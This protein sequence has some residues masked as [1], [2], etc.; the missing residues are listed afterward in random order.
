MPAGRQDET[1]IARATRDML[2]T[3]YTPACVVVNPEGQ[4]LFIHGRTGKYLEHPQGKPSLNLLD[5]AREGLRYALASALRKA[6]SS[7][8]EVRHK[9]LRVKTNG[10]HQDLDLV[11]KSLSE[12]APLNHTFMV[13]FEDMEDQDEPRPEA[14]GK[15]EQVPELERELQKVRQEYQGT[16][17]ELESSNEE[18]RSANEET[19]S[20]NEELQSTN[21]ELESS[22]EE[23]QSLNEELST[24]NS[25][26]QNKTEE[27][28]RSYES[29]TGVLDSTQIAILFLGADLSISRFTREATR[30]FNLIETD[31]GRPIGHISHRLVY[32]DFIKKVRGV[33]DT[34]QPFEDEVRTKDGNWYRMRIMTHRRSEHRI[35][36]AVVT[37]INIDPQKRFAESIVDTV[38]E[39]LL[40]LDKEF[41]VVTANRR[42]YETFGL[43]PE[44]VEANPLFELGEGQWDIPALR[45]LLTRVVSEGKDFEDCRVDHRF[46]TLG[47][48]QMLVN[49]RLL[50]GRESEAPKILM[51]IED[52]TDKTNGKKYA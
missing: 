24:V 35:E 8:E 33:L 21:E 6:R 11:V 30:I 42:F 40:V 5:T 16:L 43:A 38:R 19:R 22:R 12:P 51:A 7:G 13:L 52:I 27:L 10:G 29:I 9:R 39:S 41:R 44:Q 1:L 20:S 50:Q 49:V 26:L 3:S 4:I 48:K 46:D 45:E 18:L 47:T 32:D 15:A 2:L 31:I 25:E 28:S 14:Q 37:F 23:L 17:E 36:G 34:L